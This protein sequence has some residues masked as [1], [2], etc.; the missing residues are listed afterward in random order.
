MTKLFI[1]N[2]KNQNVCVVVEE[3]QR[4]KGLV[5]IMHG[6]GGFKEQPHLQTI[7][8]SFKRNDYTVIL[9]DTTN[10]IGESDGKMEDATLTNY[11]EDLE[12]V[13][14]WSKNQSWYQEPFVLAGHSLGGF[15][16]AYFAQNYPKKV[17]AIAPISTVV[18]GRL[19]EETPDFKKIK[20]DWEKNKIREWV[21]NSQPGLVKRLKWE[22]VEDRRKYSLLP[23][24][25]KLTMPVLMIVGDLDDTTPVVHQKMLFDLLPTENKK[26]HI[27]KGAEHTFKKEENL[28]EIEKIFDGWIKSL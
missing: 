14:E 23:E 10:S 9:F 4:Q 16:V 12:D 22:H 8:E 20:Y 24:A 26:I 25:K 5:F 1:K 6:L 28:S 21:S 18:S 13:I 11:Y 17:K 7:A 3:G 2:R 19:T 15:S 27:I